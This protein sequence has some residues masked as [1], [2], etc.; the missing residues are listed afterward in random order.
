MS[1]IVQDRFAEAKARFQTL[2]EAGE[3]QLNGHR[4][5]PLHQF[6]RR[7]IHFLEGVNFPTR[8]DE[9]WKY[10]SV[11][12]ILQP[13]YT[14]NEAPRLSQADI[15]P[16][17]IPGLDCH[18]LVFVNGVF[19]ENLSQTGDFSDGLSVIDIASALSDEK[20]Q[21]S[22][23]AYLEGLLEGQSDA[24]KIL[25]A[26]FAHHGLLIHAGKKAIV[27]KP[28]YL[29]HLAAPGEKASF[30]NHMNLIIAEPSSELSVIEGLFELPGAEGTYFNNHLNR[31]HI[32]ENAHIHHYRLQREGKEGFLVSNVDIEQDG[33][34]TF[35]SYALDL[36]GR[37]V[38]N[39]LKTKLNGSGTNTNYW[40][41]YF[42]KGEQHI[43]NHTFID[44]AVPHCISN[45]LYK[46]IVTD[47]ASGV[48]NGKVLVRKD[49]Q[50]TNA[51]QQNNNLVLSDKASMDTKPELEIFADDV[52][53]SHGATIGQ[54]D[55][56][57]VF[58][59]RS[60]G[61]PDAQ[62]R[63]MLQHAFLY[64]AIEN[65]KLEEVRLF[66]EQLVHHKFEE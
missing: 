17:L 28:A 12:R 9:E 53:C 30:N 37:L 57:A 48:F 24:F 50:K 49:A 42:A 2:F 35:S 62:A 3:S 7:A 45:E 40:G 19:Q 4:D 64:E 65:M 58:Y 46:G 21:A 66:A 31:I 14:A 16:F 5:H 18:L 44:H 32:R 51:F 20:Y 39:N 29:L 1:T 13:E 47:K 56:S 52:R 6:R 8:R 61:L 38:R 25:N 55:E 59:L 23:T 33:N 63:G 41:A 54:L 36:G 34:S 60:R 26:A 10:T 43:D 15:E 11:N 22:T 27:E